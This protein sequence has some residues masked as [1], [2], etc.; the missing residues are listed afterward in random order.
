MSNMA[1]EEPMATSAI[2][3]NGSAY[4]TWE[5]RN[6][7]PLGYVGEKLRHALEGV[8]DLA[9]SIREFVPDDSANPLAERPLP[10]SVKQDFLLSPAEA[11][12][13]YALVAFLGL[14]N[15]LALADEPEL[16]AR[17]LSLSRSAFN[18]WL[19][20]IERHSTLYA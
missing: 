20:D 11:A 12:F 7:A 2:K 18:E 3:D 9:R 5:I 16:E 19:A 17:L 4:E 1:V 10:C 8:H 13:H 15:R 14:H 6:G